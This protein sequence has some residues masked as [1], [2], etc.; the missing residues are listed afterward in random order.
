VGPHII[1]VVKIGM[2]VWMKGLRLTNHNDVHMNVHRDK[3]L[4]MK[5]TKKLKQSHYRP[6]QAP[7]VPGS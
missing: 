3:L 6:G 5:P 7:R 1:K 4:I 2:C